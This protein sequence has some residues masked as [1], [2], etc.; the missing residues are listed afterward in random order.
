MK[1]IIAKCVRKDRKHQ[2]L[3]FFILFVILESG[4]DFCQ[5]M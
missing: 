3:S 5:V 2:K 4:Y 1:K